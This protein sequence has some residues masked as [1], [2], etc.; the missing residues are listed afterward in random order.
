LR[1]RFPFVAG[2]TYTARLDLGGDTPLLHRFQVTA[3]DAPAPS[4]VAVFPSSET[5]PEN[6][7]RLYV[8]FSRPMD[9]R[10]SHRR[11]RLLD[12]AG[13]EVPLAFVEVEH[14]LWDPRR[15]RLTVFFHPGRIKRGVAPGQRLG[16]PLQAGR[17]YRLVVDAALSDAWGRGL[18][19]PFERRL[20]ATPA[21]REPPT[22]E[23][24]SL[25]APVDPGDP[26]VVD[27]PEPLDEGLLHR[28]L[29]VEKASGHAV[30]GETAVS[31]GETR[32]TFSPMLPWS[33]GSYALRVHPALEDRA[34][35]RF[36]RAFDPDGPTAEGDGTPAP[37]LR[38][39]FSVS[40]GARP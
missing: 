11:V 33:A 4:V 7:L 5:L 1:P 24:L 32:W 15:T 16:P 8:H 35:N 13:A 21:D 6:V 25:Q 34:G 18:A 37:P 22:P 31:E 26:L 12:D 30:A 36:D 3:P 10:D 40:A 38:F 17:A 20:R 23:G 29:W 9:T 2:L 19:G 39:L 27:L 14:G 28:L